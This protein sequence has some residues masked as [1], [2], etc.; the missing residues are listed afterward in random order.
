MKVAVV[1]TGHVGLITCVSL[2]SV[3]HEVVGNDAD[4]AKIDAL[5]RSEMP[6]Y[7]PGVPELLE[8]E[9]R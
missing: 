6:F 3:G 8:A 2:A 1:G 7:E 4:V 9:T 5:T